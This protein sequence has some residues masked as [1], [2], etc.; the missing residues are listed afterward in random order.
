MCRH[1]VGVKGDSPHPEDD[2]Q[3]ES[4]VA[5]EVLQGSFLNGFCVARAVASFDS[6]S[7]VCSVVLT[8]KFYTSAV[9]EHAS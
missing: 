9:I 3:R 8:L 7:L 6:S 2:A 5:T 4:K 1:G